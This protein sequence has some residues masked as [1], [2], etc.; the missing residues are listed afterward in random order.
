MGNLTLT[1][2]EMVQ[3]L[4]GLVP[5][6][7]ALFVMHTRVGNMREVQKTMVDKLEDISESVGKIGER[8]ARIEGASS[9]HTYFPSQNG[10][11]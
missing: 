6:L 4:Y 9:H 2:T 11:D 5:I 1:L 8:V 10:A 3:V 7:G